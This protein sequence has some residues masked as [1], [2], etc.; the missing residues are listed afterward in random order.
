MELIVFF[1]GIIGQIVLQVLII[2]IFA[3]PA[4]FGLALGI[5]WGKATLA[6]A[7]RPKLVKEAEELAK[8]PFAEMEQAACVSS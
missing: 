2:A 5:A 4:G 7:K 3:L 6:W 8:D 1:L